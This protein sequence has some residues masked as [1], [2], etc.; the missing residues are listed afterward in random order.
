MIDGIPNRPLYFSQKDNVD[1]ISDEMEVP[2]PVAP[3]AASLKVQR[4]VNVEAGLV[5]SRW[6]STE[7]IAAKKAY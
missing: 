4:P 3:T 2:P 6:R 5:F 1:T 7:E